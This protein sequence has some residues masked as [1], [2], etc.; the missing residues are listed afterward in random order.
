MINE[1]D[2]NEIF[3]VDLDTA[4]AAIGNCELSFPFSSC[5]EANRQEKM[6]KLFEQSQIILLTIGELVSNPDRI[7]SYHDYLKEYTEK[8]DELITDFE[9]DDSIRLESIVGKIIPNAEN[10]DLMLAH[11]LVNNAKI[12]SSHASHIWAYT[13]I[14][15]V[16]R[17][18]FFLVRYTT[19]YIEQWE[20]LKEKN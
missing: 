10:A 3:L 8:I 13:A 20:G 14:N 9:D 4:C 5:Y 19:S 11:S 12:S 6:V 15:S 18:L 17:L 2:F 16:Q 7:V 1:I